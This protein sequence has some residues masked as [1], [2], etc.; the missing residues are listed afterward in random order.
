M[1]NYY[2][3]PNKQTIIINPNFPNSRNVANM[4]RKLELP[5]NQHAVVG[6]S[7]FFTG[8]SKPFNNSMNSHQ[9]AKP[10]QQSVLQSPVQAIPLPG[11][12]PK[13]KQTF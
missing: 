1:E 8:I 9:I 12:A 11:A 6:D 10:S 5:P 13:G 3:P 2:N 7:T 4:K